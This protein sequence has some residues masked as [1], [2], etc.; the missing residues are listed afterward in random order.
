MDTETG[1]ESTQASTEAQ[2]PVTATS[3]GTQPGAESTAPNSAPE[4]QSSEP[5]IP[6][7]RF[8]EVNRKWR[9]EQQ[10][11][12]RL[13]ASGTQAPQQPQPQ[14]APK[15]ED[16]ST[17][18]EYVRADASHHARL[19]AQE[20]FKNLQKQQAQGWESQQKTKQQQDAF[21]N[22]S[23]Q[24]QA[25]AAK[26][27]T[28]K[29][30]SPEVF[31]H[32]PEEFSVMMMAAKNAGDLSTHLMRNPNEVLR[33]ASMNPHQAAM[34]LGEMSAKL[35]GSSGQPPRKPSAQVPN[36]DPVGAGT[37]N[38]NIDP[39]ATTTSVEDYVAATRPVPK[40]R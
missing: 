2:A 34:E 39:Y 27:P 6:Y 17:Y 24:M 3:E 28:V 1:T 11:N 35:A 20:E 7:S 12:A 10:E 32:W 22:W 33:L 40:R 14:G 38:G 37:K 36:L 25:A 23:T 15:Q 13:R 31:G 26:D 16:F 21:A 9:E 30:L 5:T 19:A 4:T 29:T 8:A 18:E